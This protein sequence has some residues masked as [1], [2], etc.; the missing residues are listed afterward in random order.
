M[1]TQSPL[2]AG[3][4]FAS[5]DDCDR[6]LGERETKEFCGIV[7]IW[8]QNGQAAAPLAHRGLFALQHRGEEAAGIATWSPSGELLHQKGRGLVAEC[9]P[10][11]RVKDLLGDRAIGHVRYS[12][13]NADRTENIQPFIASTPYGRLAI[14]HNGNLK[15]ALELNRE[16]EADGAL[17]STTMDTELIVHLLARS[18]APTF[19]DALRAVA[20][21]AVG[22]YS[23]TF[24]C[25]GRV[26]GLRDALGIRPLVL[27]ALK[28]GWVIASETCAL[29]AMGATFERE[30]RP[31][32]LVEIGPEGIK[33]TQL[34]PSDSPAPCV[35]ELVYFSRP[36]STVFGQS[37]YAA[38]N[39]MG[40]ELARQDASEPLRP[41]VVIPIPDSGNPAAVGY[42][43]ESGIPLE[44]G[45]IRSHY[46]GRTF[47][48]PDQDSRSHRLRLKLSV[49]RDVVANKRVVLIDDSVVR[50][51]T[52]RMIVKMVREAG[53]SEVWMRVASPPIAWP[54]YL[55]IDT[56]T[57]EE[58]IINREGSVDGV[59]RF[60]G[61]DNLRYLSVEALGRAVNHG[62][63]CYAC[64]NGKYP[65]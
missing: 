52:S 17:M 25:D 6:D 5:S 3:D 11:Y 30:V 39:R 24:L 54:C 47:I 35:F 34:L 49:I 2:A 62:P 64:M 32:E 4:P 21:R 46:V 14:A 1:C 20:K 18:H 51:N 15:N 57:R 7:A 50:G 33:S 38:R 26:Y 22:A 45:I 48:L 41:D 8:R 19:A 13:V 31:G 37:V 58:L 16:L 53:A 43:R 40:V 28:D 12:T 10:T 29:D 55:G 23:L 65:V 59:A 56:P 42:A 36:N 44:H 27:G 61:C 9:L 63:H 60:L